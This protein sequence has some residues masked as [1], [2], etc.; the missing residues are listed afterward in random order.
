MYDSSPVITTT[1]EAVCPEYPSF[2]AAAAAISQ[3]EAMAMPTILVGSP[4]AIRSPPCSYGGPMS[5]WTPSI[6]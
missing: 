6:P 4:S 3:M 5:T 1:K 2:G